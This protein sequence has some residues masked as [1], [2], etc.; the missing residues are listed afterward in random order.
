MDGLVV[1]MGRAAVGRVL[2]QFLHEA[3]DEVSGAGVDPVII[4]AKLR[5]RV[6]AVD[7]VIDSEA[8]FIADDTYLSKLDHRKAV[9]YHGKPRDA[10]GYGAE[11]ALSCRAI[12]SRS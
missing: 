4:V 7:L 1:V 2:A 12:S 8:G 3:R 11:N 6:I 9:G 10:E 5:K